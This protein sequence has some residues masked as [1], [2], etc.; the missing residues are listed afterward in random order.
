MYVYM[1]HIHAWCPQRLEE[2]IEPTRVGITDSCKLPDIGA[3]TPIH[4]I[5]EQQVILIA[6]Q[7]L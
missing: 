3:R 7:S 6:E 1:H 2:C 4:S 5:Q